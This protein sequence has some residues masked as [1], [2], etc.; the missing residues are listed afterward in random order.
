MG[1]PKVTVNGYLVEL[2]QPPVPDPVLVDETM[3]AMAGM[4]EQAE[5]EAEALATTMANA[6]AEAEETGMAGWG[7]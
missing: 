2:G 4:F 1:A 6:A 7:F 5:V 3:E